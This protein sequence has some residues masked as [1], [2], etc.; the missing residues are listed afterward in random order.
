MC[1]DVSMRE[2]GYS[3]EE[4]TVEDRDRGKGYHARFESLPAAEAG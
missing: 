4:K 3:D 2:E 1:S